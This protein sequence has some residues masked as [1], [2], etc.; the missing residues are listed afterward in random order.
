LVSITPATTTVAEGASTT[1][2]LTRSV[3]TSGNLPVT[4]TLSSPSSTGAV[5]GTDYQLVQ[6]GNPLPVS[7]GSGTITFFGSN[8]T[9][10]VVF[11][12]LSDYAN[13]L[14]SVTLALP[15]GTYVINPAVTNGGSSAIS[16]T[17]TVLTVRLGRSGLLRAWT[18]AD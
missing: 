18:G 3:Y 11:S 14:A 15:G 17:N 12:A 2:T 5:Y 9:A 7:G 10:A 6:N 4:F 16:I 1:L 13:D 8:T